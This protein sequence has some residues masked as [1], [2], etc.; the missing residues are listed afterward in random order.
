[1]KRIHRFYI[2]NEGR[3]RSVNGGEGII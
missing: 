3:Q 1:V 2:I